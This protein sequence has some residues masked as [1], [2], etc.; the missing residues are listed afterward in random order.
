MV[1][2][3]AIVTGLDGDLAM[4]QMRRHSACNHCELN[5][6]CGTGAIGRLLGHRSRP[7]TIR[8]KLNLKPGDRVLLGMPDR[9]FLR[10]SLLIYGLPLAGLI[11][12]GLVAQWAFSE[13]ELYVF[14]FSAAGFIAGLSSS[15]I[16]AKIHFSQQFNPKILQVDGEPKN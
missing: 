5:S 1:E 14:I 15:S 7:L 2:E 12:A 4:I 6:G 8:N 16:I 10:A 13:S 9:A 3:Q 11:G